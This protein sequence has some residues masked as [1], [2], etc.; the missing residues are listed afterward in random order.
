MM[1]TIHEQIQN[2]PFKNLYWFSRYLMNTDQYGAIGKLKERKMLK[3]ISILEN[4]MTQEIFSETDKL[5]LLKKTLANEIE[6]MTTVGTKAHSLSLNLIHRLEQDINSIE[7]VIVFC[8]AMKYVVAPINQAIVLVPA[9][10]K[11][12]CERA[13]KNILDTFGEEKVDMLIQI[14]DDLGVKGCLD[15]ERALVVENFIKFVDNLSRLNIAHSDLDDNIM[16]TAFLQ[17]FERR[18]GQKRKSRGGNS[19]ESVA[20]F[21]FNYYGFDSTDKPTHF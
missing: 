11:D 16:M 12:F 5:L 20:D 15:V 10:D 2:S 21:I 4:L 14:W 9:D 6:N 1:S 17:E 13:A 19:L 8:I 7:D 3:L 18:L